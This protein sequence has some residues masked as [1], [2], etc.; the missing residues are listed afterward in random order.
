MLLTITDL[1]ENDLCFFQQDR[2][3]LG[4]QRRAAG[5]DLFKLA[6]P[7]QFLDLLSPGTAAFEKLIPTLEKYSDT[8]PCLELFLFVLRHQGVVPRLDLC[9]E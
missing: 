6:I 9:A 5:I 2:G 8:P 3:V 7:E 1:R 4:Q